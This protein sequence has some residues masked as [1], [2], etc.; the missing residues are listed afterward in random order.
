MH[1][2]GK[3]VLSPLKGMDENYPQD[4]HGADLIENFT[5]NPRT[6]GWDN[7]IGWE[8][9][10]P[11]ASGFGTNAFN[12]TGRIDSLFIWSRHQGSQEWVVFETGGSLYYLKPFQQELQTLQSG[13]HIPAPNEAPT[14][15]TPVG[16]WLLILNGTDRPM[17]WKGWP[18]ELKTGALGANTSLNLFDLGWYITPSPPQPWKTGGYTA[19]P[20][21]IPGKWCPIGSIDTTVGAIADW[22]DLEK[23]TGAI[24]LNFAGSGEDDKTNKYRYKISFVNISGS[25]SPISDSSTTVE[26]TNGA[27][28]METATYGI[29]LDIPRGPE[30]TIARRIYRTYN[31]ENNT[32]GLFYY[33]GQIDNNSEEIFL[34]TA[35]DAMLGAQAP[36]VSDSIPF[37]SPKAR[38]AALFNKCLFI[39]GGADQDTRLYYSDPGQPDTYN[40]LSFID[41]SGNEGGGITGLYAHY[42]VL[43]VLRERSIDVLTGDYVN[44]FN[45]TTLSQG[46]GARAPHSLATIPDLGVVFLAEDGL[47]LVKGGFQGGAV[48]DVIKLSERIQATFDRLNKDIM[49]RAV[50]T[51][52]QKWREYHVYFPADGEDRPTLGVVLHM[53]NM[54]F[55]VRK[56]FPVGCVTTNID[57]EIIFGHHTGIGSGASG[58][59][60]AGLF[61][62]SGARQCGYTVTPAGGGDYTYADAPACTAKWRSPYHNFGEP[63]RKKFVKYVYLYMFTSGNNTISLSYFKDYKFTGLVT[64]TMKLQPADQPDLDVYDAAVLG[65]ALWERPYIAELRFPIADGACSDFQ[66]EISTTNDVVLVGYSI[67]YQVTGT[68]TITAKRSA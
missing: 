61:V 30:G 55:S 21:P 16:R 3:L 19:S 37:P 6:K 59:A 66:F 47:Y 64:P 13:R 42:G 33:V 40:A 35:S 46:I 36:G 25:E 18:L 34:D 2:K 67:E 8:K 15:Y 24:A 17:K 26:W 14:S 10:L 11:S 4:P 50:G 44:G 27:T 43:L 54:Q 7:R 22:F 5:I 41:L 52:S 38:F 63:E 28:G 62:V 1:T 29:M 49:G 31:E 53:A 57:G 9:Y 65:T 60:N 20:N 45:V 39:D 58:S 68:K 56:D 12:A 51:Y 48:V 23:N 32:T